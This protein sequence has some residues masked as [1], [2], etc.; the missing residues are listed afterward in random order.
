MGGRPKDNPQHQSRAL[1]YKRRALVGQLWLRGYSVRAIAELVRMEAAKATSELRGC[2]KT[3]HVT[4]HYDVVEN[5]KRWREQLDDPTDHKRSDQVARLMD[6]QH[7]AWA[8]FGGTPRERAYARAVYLRIALETEEKL[9]KILGTIAPTR[10][11]GGDG[12]PLVTPE[13]IFHFSSPN[14]I[15]PPRNGDDK[16]GVKTILSDN[17]DNGH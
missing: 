3:T 11:T 15:K 7:Q 4:V 17:G 9:A 5:R 8:D 12:E 6:I 2:E 16:E 13:V 14:V 10:I 1:T